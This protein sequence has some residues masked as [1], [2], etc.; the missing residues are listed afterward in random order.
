MK[1]ILFSSFVV[2]LFG[3]PASALT[4]IQPTTQAQLKEK[5][6]IAILVAK[7]QAAMEKQRELR[8]EVDEL[9]DV[10]PLDS[11]ERLKR[12]KDLR[13]IAASLRD[14][15]TKKSEA[16]G[17]AIRRTAAL[18]GIDPG[19]TLLPDGSTRP[20][21]SISFSNRLTHP[22][23]NRTKQAWEMESAQFA[24]GVKHNGMT[25][26][27]GSV[28]ITER[29][30]SSPAFL[31]ATMAHE[32]VHNDQ[33]ALGTRASMSPHA[34][35]LSARNAVLNL[36]V[37]MA[38]GAS[39]DDE[40]LIRSSADEYLSR[41]D[42]YFPIQAAPGGA[43]PSA[44]GYSEFGVD[45]E[46]VARMRRDAGELRSSIEQQQ[47]SR[48]RESIAW[49]HEAN[50][51]TAAA[52]VVTEA[53]KCGLYQVDAGASRYRLGSTIRTVVLRYQDNDGLLSSAL[54]VN[55][56]F[57]PGGDSPCNEGMSV[58]QRRWGERAFQDAIMVGRG[59][60]E[61]VGNCFLYL[62]RNLR[63]TADFSEVRKIVKEYNDSRRPTD[64]RSEPE[65]PP[66][67]TPNPVRPIPEP[68]TPTPTRPTCRYQGDWCK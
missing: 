63:P 56:C 16:A 53:E 50:A 41:P 1:A 27:D 39:K 6:E 46:A 58:L 40:R 10:W 54:L 5:A 8:S 26:S 17:E 29:A 22:V 34:R 48:I 25:W 11:K 35:E 36:D 61:G 65:T 20:P 42:L 47:M 15:E 12:L 14:L 60:D 49:I 43:I 9:T 44:E 55:A 23:F 28:T 31:A 4:L 59:T 19:G 67:P 30:F 21:W 24:P 18:Y 38:I 51:N 66:A 33:H 3:L 7:V 45:A 57:R 68:I 64:D 52:Q 13:V 2:A 62:R 37:L 32:R